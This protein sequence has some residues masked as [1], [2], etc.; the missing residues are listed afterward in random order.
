[1]PQYHIYLHKDKEEKKI[2]DSPWSGVAGKVFLKVKTMELI[3][4]MEWVF[5]L[6]LLN[7]VVCW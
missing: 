1:M 7:L 3:L 5:S 6:V 4:E 2:I